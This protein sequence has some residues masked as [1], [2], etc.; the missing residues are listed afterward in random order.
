MLTCDQQATI[1]QESCT[2]KQR[3]IYRGIVDITGCGI[4]D[5]VL[6]QIKHIGC[7]KLALEEVGIRAR[8]CEIAG[9]EV[10]SEEITIGIDR[11]CFDG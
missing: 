1:S 6:R 2:R 5:W 3:W 7:A 11:G 8:R 4:E 9:P 10:G